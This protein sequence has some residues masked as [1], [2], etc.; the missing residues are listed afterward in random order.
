MP[1][2]AQASGRWL[3]PGALGE[4]AWACAHFTDGKADLEGGRHWPR[5]TQSA[6]D[7]WDG[8]PRPELGQVP[9]CLP[10]QRPAPPERPQCQHLFSTPPV[11]GRWRRPRERRWGRQEGAYWGWGDGRGGGG[12]RGA[13]SQ[14]AGEERDAGCELKPRRGRGVRCGVRTAVLPARSS[15]RSAD[16]SWDAGEA[17][18]GEE[19][20]R[21][22]SHRAN[23][24]LLGE[25]QKVREKIRNGLTSQQ[26]GWR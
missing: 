8:T 21:E 24:L 19:G 16:G 22:Q 3:L 5:V 15:E 23:S 17:G 20:G 6:R 1:S 4:G 2:A 18:R 11:P 26:E 9:Q 13:E 12:G 10:N 7:S 14:G 25:V